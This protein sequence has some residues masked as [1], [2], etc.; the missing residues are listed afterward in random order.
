MFSNLTANNT[1][2]FPLSRLCNACKNGDLETVKKLATAKNVNDK[3]WMGW[4]PII[5]GNVLVRPP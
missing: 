2:L 3:G 5:K 4:P 1:W